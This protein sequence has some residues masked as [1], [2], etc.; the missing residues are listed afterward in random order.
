MNVTL[1]HYPISLTTS[2]WTDD[3]SRQLGMIIIQA[4]KKEQSV[5][6]PGL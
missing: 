1:L 6:L 4:E 3:P 5:Q 2:I